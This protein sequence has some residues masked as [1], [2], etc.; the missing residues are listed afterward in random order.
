MAAQLSSAR[1]ELTAYLSDRQAGRL[2]SANLYVDRVLID[3]AQIPGLYSPEEL[4]ALIA[5]LTE[6]RVAVERDRAQNT[7]L[8]DELEMLLR[9]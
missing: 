2:H 8:V 6:Y 7:K 3:C 9:P 5:E 1:S 4:G